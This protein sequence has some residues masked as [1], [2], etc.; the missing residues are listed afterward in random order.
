MPLMIIMM[1][2]TRG[3]GKGKMFRKPEEQGDGSTLERSRRM[4]I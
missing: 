4:E 3:A 1:S 2:K